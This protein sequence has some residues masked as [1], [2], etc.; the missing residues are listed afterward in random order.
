MAFNDS[1]LHDAI[2]YWFSLLWFTHFSYPRFL[3]VL[4]RINSIEAFLPQSWY[5]FWESPA[6][7]E[8]CLI[9]LKSLAPSSRYYYYNWC[10]PHMPAGCIYRACF[11]D[12]QHLHLLLC[13]WAFFA[14]WNQYFLPFYGL[15][16]NFLDGIVCSTNA[17]NFDEV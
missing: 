7:T 1:F 11:L 13:Y 2:S 8:A 14:I 3:G 6:K 4:G 5:T 12:C 16:F 15:S 17:F 10:P 9:L